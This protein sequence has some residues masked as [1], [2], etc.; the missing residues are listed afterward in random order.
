MALSPSPS[1]S[2]AQPR[3]FCCFKAPS[4]CVPLP[5]P[6]LHLSETCLQYRRDPVTLESEVDS[7][8]VQGCSCETSCGSSPSCSCIASHG[9]LSPKSPEGLTPTRQRAGCFYVGTPPLL[10]LDAIPA[11]MPLIECGPA[12][13][14]SASCSNRVSQEGVRCAALSGKHP[15][16]YFHCLS[17]APACS[18]SLPKQDS[19]S[20]QRKTWTKAP[21]SA[22]TPVA[23]SQWQRLP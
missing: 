17:T 8:A 9:E 23:S 4:P 19:A 12:C 3:R 1:P 21:S 13:S 20:S 6:A 2:R 11:Q 5:P 15:L 18:S 14:C 10:V 7:L 16:T 22:T